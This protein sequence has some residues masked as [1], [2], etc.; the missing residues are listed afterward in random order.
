MDEEK[1]AGLLARQQIEDC[2]FRYMR[3][4]DRLNAALQ[5][6]AFH[7]DATVDYGFFTGSGADFVAFAQQL[8][9]ERYAATHHMIGQMH[10]VVDG[11]E[12]HGEIYFLAWHRRIAEAGGDD[13]LIAGRYLDRYT[14]RDG[15]WRISQRREV[16]DW[17]RT[18][19][20]SDAWFDRTPEAL[21]GG[22][23]EQDPSAS[24]LFT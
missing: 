1:I 2:L 4:Q 24:L 12:G 18:D 6:S 9:A 11:A 10:I 19:A 3:G 20:A 15:I 17:T 8:L 22:R 21:R 5:R 13:L 16:V 7:D 14:C 23:R